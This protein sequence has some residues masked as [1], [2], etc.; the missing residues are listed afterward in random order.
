[1]YDGKNHG[2]PVHF[3]KKNQPG[4]LQ[5]ADPVTLETTHLRLGPQTCHLGQFLICLGSRSL[6]ENGAYP[7]IAWLRT[8]CSSAKLQL[9]NIHP[10]LDKP[11]YSKRI[12][13]ETK[14]LTPS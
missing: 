6:S 1:V 11:K 2:F 9:L 8:S 10:F 7:K 5:G 12:K 13:I 4:D 14:R 3:L